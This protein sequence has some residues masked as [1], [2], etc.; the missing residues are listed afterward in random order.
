LS[1]SVVCSTKDLKELL[2]CAF[3][4]ARNPTID[5]FEVGESILTFLRI[6]PPKKGFYRG[7]GSENKKRKHEP[8]RGVG[9]KA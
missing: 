5:A 7:K 1:L 6:P 2:R 4:A 9:L 3:S 8:R